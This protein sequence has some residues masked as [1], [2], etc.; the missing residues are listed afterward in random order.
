[1]GSRT[2][3][4]EWDLQSRFVQPTAGS[5]FPTK[6]L[7][8]KAAKQNKKHEKETEAAILR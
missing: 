1:M 8:E 6:Q 7:L 3:L 2:V 4:L 5:N